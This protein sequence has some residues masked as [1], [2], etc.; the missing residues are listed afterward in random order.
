MSREPFDRII[1]MVFILLKG[2]E[3]LLRRA[4]EEGD[5]RAGGSDIKL[6][7]TGS[8]GK[9]SIFYSE[10]ETRARV[11]RSREAEKGEERKSSEAGDE[12]PSPAEL[13]LRRFEERKEREADE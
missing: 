1:K 7:R 11:L 4:I 6:R 2:I 13:A 5:L 3:D 12:H 8:E 9:V 10:K